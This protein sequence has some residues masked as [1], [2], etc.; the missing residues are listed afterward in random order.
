MKKIKIFGKQ[1]SAT[2]LAILLA[3]GLATAGVLTY[4]GKI[5]ATVDVEQSVKLD[6][7]SYPQSEIEETVNGVAGSQISGDV[8]WLTN[9]NPD[10]DAIVSLDSECTGGPNGCDGLTSVTPKFRLDAVVDSSNDDLLVI[11]PTGKWSDF[12]SV[13]FDYFITKDS[14]Y[15]NTPHVN[16]AL[17]DADGNVMCL[18]VSNEI[19]TSKGEWKTATFDKSAMESGSKIPFV[20][21]GCDDLE[22]LT[23]NSVTIE[24][25]DGWDKIQEGQ[26]QTVWVKNVKV[27]GVDKLWFRIPNA[28]YGNEQARTVHFAMEYDFDIASQGG[29]YTVNTVV[30]PHGVYTQG[31]VWSPE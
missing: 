22:D 18:L 30:T 2:L 12:E 17:R 9:A 6:G 15:T 26:E 14:V 16:I 23:Y 24:V 5:T 1:I 11:P 8:H 31:G 19:P 3:S 29:T 10:V 27:N 7:K 21:G 4:Y 25:A 28:N 20:D 13:S